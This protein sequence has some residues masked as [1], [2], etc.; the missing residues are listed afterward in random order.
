MTRQSTSNINREINRQFRRRGVHLHPMQ[1]TLFLLCIAAGWGITAAHYRDNPLPIVI[2]TG[3][4]FCLMFSLQVA[5]QWEEAIV[6][7]M[8]R[9]H[10]LRGPGAFWILPLVDTIPAWIDHRVQ[11]T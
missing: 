10:A 7:R 5:A 11:T 2:A 4:G 6:L 1:L 3:V 8:G 9:F